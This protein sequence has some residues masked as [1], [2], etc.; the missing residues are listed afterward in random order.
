MSNTIKLNCLISQNSVMGFPLY[1]FQIIPQTEK[2]INLSMYGSRI[3]HAIKE[4]LV[5]H[6][7]KDYLF[8]QNP[9]KMPK[10][11][12]LDGVTF[13]LREEKMEPLDPNNDTHIRIIDRCISSQIQRQLSKMGYSQID[14]N[15]LYK[16]EFTSSDNIESHPA[17]EYQIHATPKGRVMLFVD[18]QRRWI[19]PL[20]KFIETMD[21]MPLSEKYKS[22]IGKDVMVHQRKDKLKSMKII[23]YLDIKHNLH[24]LN[25]PGN[26]TLYDYWNSPP[27]K[28]SSR[29]DAIK[30]KLNYKPNPDDKGILILKSDD[31]RMD[32]PPQVL[33]IKLDLSD[34]DLLEILDLNAEKSRL[35]PNMRE[36]EIGKLFDSL[37]QEN[38]SFFNM[39]LIFKSENKPTWGTESEL[40]K[41]GFEI[42]NL[43]MPK[44]EFANGFTAT[45]IRNQNVVNNAL[46]RVGPFSGPKNVILDLAVPQNTSPNEILSFYNHVERLYSMHKFGT[47]K[48][49]EVINVPEN[50][51]GYGAKVASFYY[52]LKDRDE[53]LSNR[54]V[55]GILPLNDPDGC[56]HALNNELLKL[57]IP[58]KCMRLENFKRILPEKGSYHLYTIVSEIYERR[59][60][61][62]EATWILAEKAGNCDEIIRSKLTA[63]QRNKEKND[64][65]TI[66]I[67]F[68]VSRVKGRREIASYAAICEPH[69]RVICHESLPFKGEYLTAS[70]VRDVINNSL[71]DFEM[72]RRQLNLQTPNQVI[73]FK[74]GDTRGYLGKKAIEDGLTLAKDDLVKSE[75]ASE[76]LKISYVLVKK[77]IIHRLF[78]EGGPVK[79]GL[80][81]INRDYKSPEAI[82]ITT[83]PLG[84]DLTQAPNKLVLMMQYNDKD[85]TELY[86]IAKEYNDLRFLHWETWRIQPGAALPLHIVQHKAKQLSYGYDTAY[87]PK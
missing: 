30:Q 36:A 42:L 50:A 47:I 48:R 27:S 23:E 5:V 63:N 19:C 16:P 45:F 38:F 4:T 33:R 1:R 67:G 87:T 83:T 22:L 3:S 41:D 35:S 79:E 21:N 43:E 57:N 80:C 54:F 31:L 2:E 8:C 40:K 61:N 24:H 77:R 85:T 7:G 69:G 55:I 10:C 12:V 17:V 56:H 25:I 75:R 46:Q 78:G 51:S 64:F 20:Q 70:N 73:F 39:N 60:K 58:S 59:L 13:D 44:L 66:Y 74:D 62:G 68:D 37:Y 71:R 82:L 26:P 65:Y 34:P 84:F 14:G 76:G 86:R 28:E 49:G 53:D 32:Y 6:T 15:I 9:D 72:S 52:D 11:V 29:L 81:I 18:V